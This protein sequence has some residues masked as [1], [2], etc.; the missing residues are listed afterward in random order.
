VC[1][2]HRKKRK[3]REK[4]VLYFPLLLLAKK[5]KERKG[6]EMKNVLITKKKIHKIDIK[7]K[8][9]KSKMKKEKDK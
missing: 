4:T 6:R 2:K 1:R 9:V 8:K 3:E 5:R 7:R